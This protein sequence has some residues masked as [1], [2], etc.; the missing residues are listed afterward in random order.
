MP[1]AQWWLGRLLQRQNWLDALFSLSLTL[2]QQ[3]KQ[4]FKKK[5]CTLSM[6]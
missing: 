5:N 6:K 4:P 2:S 3:V 1:Q